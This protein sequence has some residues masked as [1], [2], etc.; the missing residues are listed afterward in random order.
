M[1]VYYQNCRGLR[2]KALDFRLNLLT[3]NF[4]V[5]AITETWLNDS[6]TSSSYFDTRYT[7]VRGDKDKPERGGGV[8]LALLSE[9]N[10]TKLDAGITIIENVWIRLQLHGAPLTIG[11]VYFPPTLPVDDVRTTFNQ[12]Q[13]FIL[14]LNGKCLILGDFNI[15]VHSNDFYSAVKDTLLSDL[16]LVCGLKQ[17]NTIINTENS[18]LDIVMSDLVPTVHHAEEPLVSEDKYHPALAI[19]VPLS[20]PSRTSFPSFSCWNFRKGDYTQLYDD[21]ANCNWNK[22]LECKDPHEAAVFF[23]Q[24]LHELVSKNIP[25][26]KIQKQSRAAFPPWY[27]SQLINLLKQ[28]RAMHRKYKQTN[29]SSLYAEYSSIRKSCKKLQRENFHSH[30]QNIEQDLYH[31]PKFFWQY[32]KKANAQPQTQLSQLLTPTGSQVENITE[33]CN[34]LADHFYTA[35][36]D[37]NVTTECGRHCEKGVGDGIGCTI[38]SFGIDGKDIT[39]S[40][41]KLK[42]KRTTA[43]SQVP[44]FVYKGIRESLIAPLQHIFSLCLALGTYPES[45]KETRVL[46]LHKGGTLSPGNFR[47]IS[48]LKTPA[49]IFDNIIH[50]YLQSH[51]LPVMPAE[52]HGFLPGKSVTSNLISLTEFT[53]EAYEYGNQVDVVYFDLSKA[54]DTVDHSILLEKL[55]HVGVCGKLLSLIKHY[56]SNRS[57]KVHSDPYTSNTY[58]P[59]CGVPQGSTLGPLLFNIY[60]ID[61]PACTEDSI[62]LMY[63]D[64]TKL[65]RQINGPHDAEAL[66]RDINRFVTWCSKN[67]LKINDEKCAIVSF[68][69]KK[70]VHLQCY[71]VSDHPIVRNSSIRDLGVML[72]AKLTFNEHIDQVKTKSLRTLGTIL[73]NN[74][75]FTNPQT[76]I[77]LFR[78]LVI[79]LLMY[80]SE[81]WNGCTLS[82][83]IKLENVQS[84]FRRFMARKF[85]TYK[86]ENMQSLKERR[87]A[88]DIKYL[89]K[90]INGKIKEDFISKLY[91][92][93]PSLNRRSATLTFCPP[94]K[95]KLH[96]QRSPLYRI[97]LLYNKHSTNIDLF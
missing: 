19:K 56:I 29:D 75:G 7:V 50:K 63:A 66:Q 68:T 92:H 30:V 71:K 11:C 26:H 12:M 34:L 27:S 36:S 79:P 6:H 51:V 5:I 76:F 49:K 54:F 44:S 57:C 90:I 85:P 91:F 58:Q 97:Q 32:I 89:R 74:L 28:K 40:I 84:I 24:T 73:R 78:T 88:S 65:A 21:A 55:H 22:V 35:S 45:W 33:A 82:Q 39:D 10:Y 4:P 94:L 53:M 1:F 69:N 9:F 70:N 83:N 2:T 96:S 59:T 23:D 52:Q 93:V 20:L 64:D 72:D 62:V 13:D 15:N 81:L 18:M 61:L 86:I 48:L 41:N 60:T 38:T 87:L 46:P 95:R 8:A 67:K 16:L 14:Q 80:C 17:H 31:Q 47:P 77:H 37:Q 42:S 43:S 25:I 3:Q